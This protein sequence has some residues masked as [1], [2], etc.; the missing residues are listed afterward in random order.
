MWDVDDVG[1][2][3]LRCWE[4]RMLEMGLLGMWDAGDVGCWGCGIF[5]MWDV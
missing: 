4:C 1:Y 2:P 3:E 5:E